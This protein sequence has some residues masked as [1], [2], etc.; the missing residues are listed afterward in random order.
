MLITRIHATVP[1]TKRTQT[2][3]KLKRISNQRV[4][5]VPD[6]D[7]DARDNRYD[8]SGIEGVQRIVALTE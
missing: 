5:V 6:V 1:C 2:H 8:P 3:L 7:V 4:T